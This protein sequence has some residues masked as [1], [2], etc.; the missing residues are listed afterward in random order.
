VPL[1]FPSDSRPRDS[2]DGSLL[3]KPRQGFDSLR[4][5]GWALY[6]LGRRLGLSDLGT[7]NPASTLPGGGKSDHAFWP[8]RAFDLGLT[9]V[10]TRARARWYFKRCQ[11]RPE[12]EYVIF[13]ELIW[14]RTNGLRKYTAGGHM[15][16][17]HVSLRHPDV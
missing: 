9:K 15:T 2:R 17:V 4:R 8:A 6:T 5:A 14:S 12:V 7:H 10:G 3:R 11:G 1:T 16:H 13:E